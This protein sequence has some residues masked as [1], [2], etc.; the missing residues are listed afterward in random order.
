M[1]VFEKVTFA[2]FIERILDASLRERPFELDT[3]EAFSREIYEL[4]A[5]LPSTANIY[6]ITDARVSLHNDMFFAFQVTH[7]NEVLFYVGSA[8]K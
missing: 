4:T 6:P 2:Q 1:R 3:R 5:W 8:D 7:L